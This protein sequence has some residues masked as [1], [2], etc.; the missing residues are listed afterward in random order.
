MNSERTQPRGFWSCQNQSSF[1]HRVSEL[2]ALCPPTGPVPLPEG[3]FLL[4]Q[5]SLPH[6]RSLGGGCLEPLNCVEKDSEATPK[7]VSAMT[8]ERCLPCVWM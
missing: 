8:D 2:A 1:L 5:D 6:L 7:G 4:E 3:N